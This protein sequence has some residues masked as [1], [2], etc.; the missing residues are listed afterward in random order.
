MASWNFPVLHFGYNHKYFGN[1]ISVSASHLCNIKYKQVT[2]VKTNILKIK[3]QKK[4][5]ETTQKVNRLNE[6][7]VDYLSKGSRLLLIDGK[8]VPAVSGRTLETVNPA[9]ED[10]L[11][12]I[13]EGGK[14]DV[15]L[16]VK[17]ARRPLKARP[18]RTFRPTKGSVTSTGLPILLN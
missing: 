17:A 3:T 1:K 6:A 12:T 15:D 5:M 14:E 11:T 7:V 10:V 9:T 4:V 8:W 2:A 13:A 18:G 16:A